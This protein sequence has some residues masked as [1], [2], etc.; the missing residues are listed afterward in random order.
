MK[1][2]PATPAVEEV[3]ITLL[4]VPDLFTEL[5]RFAATPWMY[6]SLP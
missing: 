5:M 2:G 6:S 1:S 3:K 4:T